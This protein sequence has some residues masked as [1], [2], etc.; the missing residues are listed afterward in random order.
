MQAGYASKVGGGQDHYQRIDQLYKDA[1]D[2][3]ARAALQGERRVLTLNTKTHK[4]RV[5]TTKAKASLKSVPVSAS[6]N[7]II[8]DDWED[9]RIPVIDET[10]DGIRKENKIQDR[11][12]EKKGLFKWPGKPSGM[13]YEPSQIVRL[14]GEVQEAVT[15][16]LNISTDD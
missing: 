11:K 1:Q 6:K 9:D 2:S 16:G 10:D 8:Q 4:V 5:Q 14:E 7:K 15:D 12:Q 13:T 3:D